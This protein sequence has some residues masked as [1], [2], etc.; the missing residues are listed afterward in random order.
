VVAGGLIMMGFVKSEKK[1]KK[2]KKKKTV[3]VLNMYSLV[4]LDARKRSF[5]VSR[6]VT[7][8]LADES[9]ERDPKINFKYYYLSPDRH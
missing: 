1:K 5:F 9:I 7:G 3:D 6:L 8:W 4:P 2:K